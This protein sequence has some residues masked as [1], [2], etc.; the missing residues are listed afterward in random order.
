MHSDGIGWGLLTTERRCALKYLAYLKFTAILHDNT[1]GRGP[2][3]GSNGFDCVNDVEAFSHLS[4]HTV[5]SVQPRSIN[6]ANEK[7]GPAV[8]WSKVVV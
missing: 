4:E 2:T 1:L 8:L 3:L 7:L 6:R 5:S